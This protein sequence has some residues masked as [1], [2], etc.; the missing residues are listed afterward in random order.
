MLPETFKIYATDSPTNKRLPC[1]LGMPTLVESMRQ[2]R[3]MRN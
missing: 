3:S 1:S 2:Q